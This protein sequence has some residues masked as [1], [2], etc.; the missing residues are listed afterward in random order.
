MKLFI[1]KRHHLALV[2]DLKGKIIGMVTLEDALEE[3]VGDIG[4][5]FDQSPTEIIQVGPNSWKVGGGVLLGT[6][7]QR[8]SITLE[9]RLLPKLLIRWIGT[10]IGGSIY[11][12]LSHKIGM[13]KLAKLGG[14]KFTK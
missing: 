5:E 9:E 6:L 14:E 13:T 11:L 2:K 12:G 8:L 1:A 3:I 7:A 10:K 4:D